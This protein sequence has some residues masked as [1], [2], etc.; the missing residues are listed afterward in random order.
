MELVEVFEFKGG[1]EWEV[2]ADRFSESLTS[3]VQ[4]PVK[5]KEAQAASYVFGGVPARDSEPV[6]KIRPTRFKDV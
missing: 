2:V 6:E 3:D 4:V 5:G 1:N